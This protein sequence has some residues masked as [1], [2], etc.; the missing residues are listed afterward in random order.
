MKYVLFFF[1]LLLA[2]CSGT[3]Q[4]KVDYNT[5]EPLR[6]AVLPFARVDK[7][8]KFEGGDASLLIDNVPGVSQD[9]GKTPQSI[10]RTSVEDELDNTALDILAPG[11]INSRLH[12]TGYSDEKL[13]FNYQKIFD[14]SAA[15]Y[16]KKIFDC[17]A[18][19]YGKVTRWDRHYY[20]LQSATTVGIDLKLVSARTGKTLFSASAEDTDSRGLTKIPTGF[21]SLVIEPIRGLDNDITI[22]LAQQIVEKMIAPLRT[23]NKP[24]YLSTLPPSIYAAAHNGFEGSVSRDHGLIVMMTGSEHDKGAFSVGQAIVNVP[25]VERGAGHYVGVYLPLESDHLDKEPVTVALT[26]QYG[27]TTTQKLPVQLSLR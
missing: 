15:D 17:D 1:A 7:D 11:L 2:G 22:K 3:Y 16:C 20:G 18:V 24:E 4:N 26:D 5:L 14:T 9:L 6:V 27:R 12:H 19:L 13:E 21:S 23:D 25:M 8:G 10:V